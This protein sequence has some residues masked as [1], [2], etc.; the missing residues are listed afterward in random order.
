MAL[1]T[2]LRHQPLQATSQHTAVECTFDVITDD[3]GTKYLQLDT[4]GSK[5]R[6]IL[7]KKSQSLRL[8]PSAIVDLK[9]I[10]KQYG[11]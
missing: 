1:V 5:A 9:T 11:L 7:G 8:A 6:K 10:F 2:G 4:Y 3:Q